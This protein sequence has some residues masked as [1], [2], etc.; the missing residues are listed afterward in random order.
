MGCFLV[1]A[2]LLRGGLGADKAWWENFKVHRVPEAREG[3]SYPIAHK[4]D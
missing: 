2:L 4:R 1:G 3:E